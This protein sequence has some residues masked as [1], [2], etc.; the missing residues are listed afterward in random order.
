MSLDV[1]LERAAQNPLQ[2]G[3]SFFIPFQKKL[4]WLSLQFEMNICLSSVY[5]HPHI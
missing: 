3:F 5:I 4:V 2:K 1:L